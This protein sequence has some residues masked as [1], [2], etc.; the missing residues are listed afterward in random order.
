MPS[1]GAPIFFWSHVVERFALVQIPHHDTTGWMPRHAAISPRWC[2]PQ[3][4]ALV[5]ADQS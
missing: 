5:T 4:H 2:S 3:V 1:S